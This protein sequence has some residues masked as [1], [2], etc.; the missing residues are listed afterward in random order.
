MFVSCR[1]PFALQTGFQYYSMVEAI[2][3]ILRQPPVPHL[4][5]LAK[6]TP[7]TYQKHHTTVAHRPVHS[8]DTVIPLLDFVVIHF[9]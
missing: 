2:L 1:I 6:S 9:L 7:P 8:L 4:S 5:P 3:S